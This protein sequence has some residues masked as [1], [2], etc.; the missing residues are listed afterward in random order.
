MRRNKL[1]I[2]CAS[3]LVLAGVSACGKGGEAQQTKGHLESAAGSLTGSDKL[4][5]EGKK[6]E[7]VGGVKSAVGDLKDA[8][9][10]ATK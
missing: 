8:A 4:K 2:A 10:D 1:A 6:D 5:R 7:V 9:H 3:L